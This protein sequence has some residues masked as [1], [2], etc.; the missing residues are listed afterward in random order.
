MTCGASLSLRAHVYIRAHSWCC[1]SSGFGQMETGRAHQS[2]IMQ[3]SFPVLHLVTP[4]W[5]LAL[6]AVLHSP[7]QPFPECDTSGGI[8]SVAFS[9]H[10]LSLGSVHLTMTLRGFL[11]HFLPVQNI[12]PFSGYI[13]VHPFTYWKRSWWLLSFDNHEWSCCKHLRTDFCV[14]WAM[15]QGTIRIMW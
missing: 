6:T 8:D 1:T 3:Q 5:P 14:D 11:A 2:R 13:T 15:F 10:R 4:P 7:V 12:T 9:D